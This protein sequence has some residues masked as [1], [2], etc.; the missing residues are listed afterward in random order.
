MGI[1][2][3]GGHTPTAPR[4][5]VSFVPL[6][7]ELPTACLSFQIALSF[8]AAQ[9][10]VQKNVSR[11][12]TIFTSIKVQPLWSTVGKTMVPCAITLVQAITIVLIYI[13]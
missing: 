9:Q 6:G 12:C 7:T 4:E 11:T 3:E 8:L 2:E 13:Y 10:D 1:L 5:L